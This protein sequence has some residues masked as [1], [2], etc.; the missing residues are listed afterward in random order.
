MSSCIELHMSSG[1]FRSKALSTEAK[2]TIELLYLAPHKTRHYL[3]AV[4]PTVLFYL[5][6]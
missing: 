6:S 5:V 3:D 1:G 4:L 2:T